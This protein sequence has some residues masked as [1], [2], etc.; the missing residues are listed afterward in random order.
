MDTL[1]SRQP[2]RSFG[3]LVSSW[4]AQ[5]VDFTWSFMHQPHGIGGRMWQALRDGEEEAVSFYNH[6]V[7]EVTCYKHVTS[8]TD[9]S[10]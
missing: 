5:T 2:Y 8:T 4:S 3:Q 7:A 9:M 1:S 10:D 6:H